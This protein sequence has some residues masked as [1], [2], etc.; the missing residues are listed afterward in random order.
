MK[1]VRLAWIFLLVA[2]RSPGVLT[3]ANPSGTAG[4]TVTSEFGF[5]APMIA[6][7]AV[8]G[9]AAP[10]IGRNA[11]GLLVAWDAS[12]VHL[13]RNGRLAD[14]AGLA[15]GKLVTWSVPGKP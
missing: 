14:V 7:R 9:M 13:D 6:K 3:A 15:F 2:L 5:D 12:A 1:N 4:P 11:T 8:K 10:A